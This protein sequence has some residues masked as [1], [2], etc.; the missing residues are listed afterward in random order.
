MDDGV[1]NTVGKRQGKQDKTCNPKHWF[2]R[3]ER[4]A[5]I[6]QAIWGQ[7]EHCQGDNHIQGN[8]ISNNNEQTVFYF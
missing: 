7:N 2:Y 5:K 6:R 3:R 4:H 1:Q 8:V